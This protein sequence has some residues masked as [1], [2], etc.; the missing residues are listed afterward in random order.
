MHCKTTIMFF[1]SQIFLTVPLLSRTKE[2]RQENKMEIF[3]EN[4]VIF[5][6]YSGCWKVL[7]IQSGLNCWRLTAVEYMKFHCRAT[8]RLSAGYRCGFSNFCDLFL[9]LFSSGCLFGWCSDVKKSTQCPKPGM[10]VHE[11]C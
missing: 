5:L 4:K 7:G 11:S 2:S 3:Q 6:Y 10:L 9:S 1:S 8:H